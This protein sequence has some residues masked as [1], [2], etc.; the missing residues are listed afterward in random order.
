MRSREAAVMPLPSEE[1]TPP[2]TNTNLGTS[3]TSGVFLILRS[4]DGEGKAVQNDE[5]GSIACGVRWI[6]R[7]LD[8]RVAAA[9]VEVSIKSQSAEP[10]VPQLST[11]EAGV[12]DDRHEAR[13]EKPETVA[14][15][16][17]RREGRP[18]GR[19]IARRDVEPFAKIRRHVG[20]ARESDRAI[21]AAK[22]AKDGTRSTVGLD[23]EAADDD[24]GAGRDVALEPVRGARPRHVEAIAFL[25]ED[26]IPPVYGHHIDERTDS[27]VPVLGDGQDPRSKTRAEK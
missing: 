8:R 15:S 25:C 2:V 18:L 4:G 17:R 1:V 9:I 22:S 26:P 20:V 23:D 21:L 3:W 16:D 6:G 14:Q 13:V 24:I 5:A 11:L 19:E 10:R 7:N 27:Y 12:L